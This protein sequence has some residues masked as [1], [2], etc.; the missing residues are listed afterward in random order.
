MELKIEKAKLWDVKSPNLYTLKVNLIDNGT[1]KDTSITNFGIRTI[2]VKGTKI[3]LNGRPIFLKGFGRH[4]DFPIIGK[5]VN[6]AILRRDFDLLKKIGAN[7]FRTS[8]Y[9]YSRMHLDLADENGFLV[10]LEIPTVGIVKN[11][12]GS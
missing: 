10:I 2:K 1:V 7:S 11:E 6:G 5:A 12:G 3:L 9:P 8:H 4:E